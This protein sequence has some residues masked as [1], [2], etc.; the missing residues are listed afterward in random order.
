[1]SV[2]I[3]LS[4]FIISIKSCR[5]ATWNEAGCPDTPKNAP[6]KKKDKNVLL[7]P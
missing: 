1:M 6:V 3:S 5:T 4:S 7:R 2:N